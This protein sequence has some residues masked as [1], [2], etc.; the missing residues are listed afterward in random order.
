MY[1]DRIEL[2]HVDT[3]IT[4][5]MPFILNCQMSLKWQKNLSKCMMKKVT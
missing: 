4:D 2:T 3:E 5:A 1:T